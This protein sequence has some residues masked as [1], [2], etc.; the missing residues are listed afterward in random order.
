MHKYTWYR[1]NDDMIKKKVWLIV[2]VERKIISYVY[3]TKVIRRLS[4]GVSDHMIILC[5]M[6]LNCVWK[7]RKVKNINI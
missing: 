1:L 6:R 7:K 5:K 3:D 4:G 2:S